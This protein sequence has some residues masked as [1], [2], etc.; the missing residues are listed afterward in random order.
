MK[1]R[2]D[3]ETF[4]AAN[5]QLLRQEELIVDATEALSAALERSGITKA[6]LAQRLGKSKAFVTQV[7]SGRRNLTL[8]TIADVADGLGCRIRM[9]ACRD[10]EAVRVVAPAVSRLPYEARGSEGEGAWG[11]LLPGHFGKVNGSHVA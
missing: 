4:E 9:R 5:R 1:Q 11:R 3:Y 7:L 6:A 8:R 10:S 2:T